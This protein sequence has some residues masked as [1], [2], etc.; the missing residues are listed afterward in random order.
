MTQYHDHSLSEIQLYKET[1][2]KYEV[3]MIIIEGSFAAVKNCSSK[4]DKREFLMR[5]IQRARVFGCDDKIIQELKIMRMMRH[6]N[7]MTVVDYW[8]NS[9]EMCMVMEPI[10]V[11]FHSP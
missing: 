1:R 9:E 8:E 3:G 6:E 2:D 5:V 11:G 10:E 7:I 4:Q